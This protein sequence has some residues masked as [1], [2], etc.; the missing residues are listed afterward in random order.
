MEGTTFRVYDTT[1]QFRNNSGE[2][3]DWGNHHNYSH[4]KI[5]EDL[6]NYIRTLGYEVTSNPRI[7]RDYQILS[8]DHFYGQRKKLEFEASRY[9]AGFELMFY[10]N[11]N[12]GH[13]V[14]GRYGFDKFKKMPYVIRLQFQNDL[15]RIKEY[16]IS[17]GCNDT[18]E[19]VYKLAEDKIKSYL[20]NCCHHAQK[21][22]NFNLSDLDGQTHHN[23]SGRTDQDKKT[24]HNGQI[25]YFRDWDGRLK[26]GKVYEDINNMWFVILNKE[27]YTKV[28]SYELFDPTPE[29][30][31]NPRLKG[32]KIPQANYVKLINKETSNYTLLA[33][34]LIEIYNNDTADSFKVAFERIALRLG[35]MEPKQEE[36]PKK[37]KKKEESLDKV[38]CKA[39]NGTSS[40]EIVLRSS[41][42]HYI[43]LCYS[44]CKDGDG[45]IFEYDGSGSFN[46]EREMMGKCYLEFR[47]LFDKL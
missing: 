27:E 44:E 32:E 13:A 8:K 37:R 20:V 36:Q 26:R 16:L 47:E 43:I 2:R 34:K 22:M 23:G 31:K 6:L 9:P 17:L 1:L 25:K 42:G 39:S 14:S 35:Y 10:Q 29:D 3:H 30:L 28:S 11:V 21:D 4:Y 41:G 18:T 40:I 33:K 24:I 38:Y 19:Q 7:D 15:R 45:R 5:L 12:P 46:L